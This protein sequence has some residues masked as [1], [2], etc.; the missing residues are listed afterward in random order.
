MRNSD[1]GDRLREIVACVLELDVRDVPADASFHQE[2]K[3]DSLEKVEI[4]ARIEQTFGVALTDEETAAVDSVRDAAALLAAKRADAAAAFPDSPAR[5]PAGPP[6]RQDASASP[7]A[8]AGRPSLTDRLL[9][10]HLAAGHGDRTAYADPDAGEVSYARLH[11]A[12]RGYAGALRARGVPPGVRGLIVAEDS[13]ATAVAVLGLWWH[14]CV[15]VPVSPLHSDADLRF[16]AGDCAAALVH[17]DVGAARER[18]L[19]EAFA[20]LSRFTGEGVREGLRTGRA[21]DAHRPGGTAPAAARPVDREALVQ[22][23]SGSTGRPKGVRHS[24]AGITA[25]LDGFGEVMGLRP[26]DVVLSTAR[27]SFGYGFGSSVLCTLAAGASAVLLRGAVD[28]RAVAAALRRHR[29]TVLCSVPRLYAGL[30]DTLPSPGDEVTGRLRL[31]LTAGENCPAGLSLRVQE[32]FGARVM[33]CLGATEVMHV[34]VATPAAP[35]MHG[36]A[37]LPVPGVTVTVR[38]DRGVPVPDGTDGRLHIGGPTVSLG[39]V[40]RA[41]AGGATFAD[42]GAY[43]GD[44]VR[45]NPDGGIVYLCR[46]DDVLNLGGYKVVPGEIEDVVRS[47]DGVT[48]CVV[49]GTP[50]RHGLQHSVAFTVTAEGADREA[51]RRAIRASVRSRLAP[52]KRPSRFEFV[53]VLPATAT[54]KLAAYKLRERVGR[55]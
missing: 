10:V 22:Y 14:G 36:L 39:Y 51:V 29:P 26:D 24:A 41:D 21:T 25:M 33:N 18:S 11:R 34:A 17:L 44:L 20:G 46:A 32:A 48:D 12:A 30:L 3:V 31:C 47:I 37:G 42:G 15:P 9:G 6:P 52:Y 13:V 43:T 2:L 49:V 50:D 28:P 23:T 55:S 7:A 1:A 54:G 53:D 27:M 45:R 19:E 16:I 4:A 38:D 8:P 5:S 40:G 35:P